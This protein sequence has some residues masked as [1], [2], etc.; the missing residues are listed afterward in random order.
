VSRRYLHYD[1]FTG[2][3]FSGNQLAVFLD[4]R[5]LTAERMQ[6]IARE[7]GFSESTFVL[8]AETSGTDVRV[9]IFT[10]A[11]ELP[12][13]GHP[14]IGTAFALAHTGV[15]APGAARSVFGLGIGPTPVDLEWEGGALRF[16]WMTQANPTF[17]PVVTRRADVAAAIG[18]GESDL[19]ADLPVQVVS[20]GIPYLLVPF[21]SPQAVDRATVD[22][23]ALRRFSTMIGIE[24]PFFL[25]ARLAQ[26]ATDTVH[27]RMFAPGLG[28]TEDP[29]T[30]SASG[31]LGC[32]LL[33]HGLVTPDAARHIV[34]RQGVVM[35]RP[36]RIHIEVTSQDGTI[37]RVRVGGAARLVAQG[38]LLVW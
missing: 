16:A 14:T 25:F 23:S 27:A 15:I 3:P 22:G 1:V 7:I 5:G 18:V 13:A 28:V 6:A 31:P 4:G 26:D 11:V 33:R 10:P 36:S 29:A 2:Q 37:E 35:G 20:C 8:P 12:M 38:E 24:A 30:G 19:A 32:Y 21:A 9:R 34:S 17:G